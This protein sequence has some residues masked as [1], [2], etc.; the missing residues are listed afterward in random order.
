MRTPIDEK[1]T[2]HPHVRGEIFV[3][4]ECMRGEVVVLCCF[5]FFFR[6]Q[7]VLGDSWVAAAHDLPPL[8]LAPGL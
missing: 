1:N 7:T 8:A 4:G 2:L 5:V 6:S 3:G